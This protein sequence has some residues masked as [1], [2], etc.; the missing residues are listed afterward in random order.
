MSL[1]FCRIKEML[2]DPS[3][4]RPGAN[5]NYKSMVDPITG[6]MRFYEID[7]DGNIVFVDNYSF[8]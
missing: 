2:I 4:L 8:N 3:S 6:L 7:E 1:F 5:M